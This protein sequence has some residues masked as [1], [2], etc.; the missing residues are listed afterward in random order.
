MKKRKGFILDNLI[1]IQ[2]KSG[3][4]NSLFCKTIGLSSGTFKN[5]IDGVN[6]PSL[7]T[8]ITISENLGVS[9]DSLCS[10]NMKI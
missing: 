9:M 7:E 8:L 6:S 1:T 4:S 3:L 2:L 5:L 10:E